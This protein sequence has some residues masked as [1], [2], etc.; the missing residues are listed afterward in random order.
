MLEG[1]IFAFDFLFLP[2]KP[3]FFWGSPTK[4]HDAYHPAGALYLF[5]NKI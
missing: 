5:L 4:T 3:F 1:S 2:T